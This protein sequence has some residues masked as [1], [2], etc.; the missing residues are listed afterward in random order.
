MFSKPV[1]D[2]VPGCHL[3][4]EKGQIVTAVEMAANSLSKDLRLPD[5]SYLS[6]VE[7]SDLK[8]GNRSVAKTTAHIQEQF[9]YITGVKKHPTLGY[10]HQPIG[11]FFTPNQLQ[12]KIDLHLILLGMPITIKTKDGKAATMDLQIYNALTFDPHNFSSWCFT[13]TPEDQAELNPHHKTDY[14]IHKEG[15]DKLKELGYNPEDPIHYDHAL[16]LK[17]QSMLIRKTIYIV[18]VEKRPSFTEEKVNEARSAWKKLFVAFVNKVFLDSIHS[19]RDRVSHA[20]YKNL[21]W[22]AAEFAFCYDSYWPH[23][24]HACPHIFETE[25][26]LKFL[27]VAQKNDK[28]LQDFKKYHRRE[29]LLNSP[30]KKVR[31]RAAN[32]PEV[33]G[34]P[35]AILPAHLQVKEKKDGQSVTSESNRTDKSVAAAMQGAHIQPEITTDELMVTSTGQYDLRKRAKS[36]LEN[37][38][39]T[40]NK[41]DKKAEVRDRSREFDLLG[42]KSGKR[43]SESPDD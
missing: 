13:V 5:I 29:V 15:L 21:F 11:P 43:K 34:Y 42:Q 19:K 39:H 33:P 9:E 14:A 6:I 24:D 16:A 17:K 25:V 36:P 20:E 35:N 41:K 18:R 7:I 3:K 27:E 30:F 28:I 4:I 23:Y 12:D 31:A 2:Y 10:I 40:S 26:S 37:K 1:P 22:M 38:K 32:I 8:S